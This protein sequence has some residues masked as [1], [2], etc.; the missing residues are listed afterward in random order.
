[1]ASSKPVVPSQGARNLHWVLKIGNRPATFNFLQNVLGLQ[2]LR[3]EE[4]ETGCDAACNGPYDSLW[5]KTMSGA[6]RESLRACIQDTAS[7]DQILFAKFLKSFQ[8]VSVSSPLAS[9]PGYQDEDHSFVLELTYNYGVKSYARGNDLHFLLLRSPS[10]FQHVAALPASL[11][12]PGPLPNSIQVTAPDGYPFVITD[13][14]EHAQGPFAEVHLACSDLDATLQ[15]W[16]EKCLGFATAKLSATEGLVSPGPGQ[17]A[18]RFTQLPEGTALDR[19][20]AYGRVAFAVPDEGLKDIEAHVQASGYR[21][22]TPYVS[23]DTPGKAT[24]QVVILADP[25]GHEICFVGDRGFRD[26]SRVDPRAGELLRD[27]MAGD[28]S[29]AWFAAREAKIRA[30]Q[31]AQAAQ[32]GDGQ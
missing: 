9:Y 1:M 11:R 6:L 4:F 14:P 31:A 29:D 17:C 16:G 8:N 27:A 10:V 28:T 5:S 25:D 23:L 18:L 24:V 7:S 26:L 3:H 2:T 12:A 21:I 15:Y 22:H 19:G 20:E 30:Y 32:A 13:G